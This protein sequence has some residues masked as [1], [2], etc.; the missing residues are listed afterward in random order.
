M[1]K[2]VALFLSIILF[3]SVSG[4]KTVGTDRN[5]KLN[6][7]IT[8][9]I[10]EK[11][12]VDY[13][14]F[15]LSKPGSIKIDFDFDIQG[16]YT[17][18]LINTD[19]N[20]V[21]QNT[22]FSSSVN[23]VSGR[24]EQSSNKL[25]LEKGDYQIQVSVS[26]W[27]FS[28]E[29]YELKINYDAENSDRYEK[30]NNNNAKNAMVIDYNQS[31]TGNLSSSIDVDF[32]MLEIPEAGELYV[33]FTFNPDAKYNVHVYTENNGSLK[34]LQTNK[35]E[36]GVIQSYDKYF[37]TSDKLRVP[38]GNYY[39]KITKGW[40]DF[41]DDDYTFRVRYSKDYYNNYELEFND[42]AKN[43]TEI[44]IDREY[45]G[46][47]N[48]RSD[49]DYYAVDIYNTNK[50]F[51]NMN[52]ASDSAYYVTIYKEE[53][54][55]LKKISSE[56]VK[57]KEN[58]EIIS[59]KKEDII[60]GRYYFKVSSWDYSNKDYTISILTKEHKVIILEINNP[61]MMVNGQTIQVDENRGTTPIIYNNRTLL[62]VKAV[63]EAMGG[64]V[65]W[66]SVTRTVTLTLDGNVINL[67]L[68]SNI[69][70]VNGMSQYIDV[71]AISINGRTMVPV[72][73]V[74][75]NFGASVIWNGTTGAVTIN[76]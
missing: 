76:Y 68:D 43:A 26:S 28:D 8:D 36:A 57:N 41:L 39:F 69:A 56:K 23:T 2:F 5:V 20:K 66:N 1:K 33:E 27:N 38:G 60:P 59:I 74:M 14:N 30:E 24:Y 47:L 13:F 48:S 17:V 58:L 15:Y 64:S 35:F 45:I 18:K 63:I 37:I 61:Y 9:E 50:L 10:E 22:T 70:Y 72:K 62:P 7:K 25:R 51:V 67:V 73:F 55:N 19:N 53:N 42:E 29:E 65:N 3:F 6:S 4:A 44:V 16:K 40:G 54:G 31:V 75:D 46:N 12:E 52:T 34:S 21:I 32:Y 11:G 49:V 71:P